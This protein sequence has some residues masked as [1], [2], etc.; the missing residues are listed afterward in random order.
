MSTPMTDAPRS[1]AP[2][3][4][5]PGPEATSNTRA[6]GRTSA[7]SSSG[8]TSLAV[9]GTKNSSY[10]ATCCSQPA[11][12]N[13]LKASASTVGSVIANRPYGCAQAQAADART[14]CSPSGTP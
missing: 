1:A 10:P 9:I 7:A 13:V 4:T 14:G 3:V 2:A 5:W 12:S 8:P 11:A 6:P